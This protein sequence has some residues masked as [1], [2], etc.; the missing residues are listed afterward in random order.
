LLAA[1]LGFLL[2]ALLL[3]FDFYTANGVRWGTERGSLE[4]TS[5]GVVRTESPPRRLYDDLTSS[6]GLAV[7]V[8]VTSS[9]TDQTGPAR[10]VSYSTSIVSRNFTLGQDR[11]ALVVRL[12]TTRTDEN[13]TPGLEVPEVFARGIRRH[14]A[15]TY[16]LKVLCVYVDGRRRTCSPS[17]G[18]D[19]GTWDPSHHLLLG[20]EA[21]ADRP[22]LG[23]IDLVAL[24]N[25]PLAAEE[26]ERAAAAASFVTPRLPIAADGLVALYTFTE[27]S[28]TTVADS[29]PRPPVPL[30]IPSVVENVRP[31]LSHENLLPSWPLS[32]YAIID[33]VVNLLLFVPFGFLVCVVLERR[34]W[35]PVAAVVV[36][37]VA[38]AVLSLAVEAFQYC[39]VTRSSELRDVVLNALSGGFGTAVYRVQRPRRV[40]ESPA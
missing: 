34:G 20:N 18:G 11:R 22:W 28:G 27:R 23:T 31:F 15:V 2:A 7:E 30:A 33:T 32:R 8:S 12:R 39:L 35:T 16:D 13:G 17:P 1:Y 40:I 26:I 6:R 5:P 14:V 19:L 3:P 9:S 37:I 29:S 25:R 4:F 21:S 24:Y 38:A 36:T 10:I